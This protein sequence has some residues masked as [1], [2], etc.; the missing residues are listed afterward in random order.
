MRSTDADEMRALAAV[1]KNSDSD[2]VEGLR[3]SLT[4]FWSV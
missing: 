2:F 1:K 4:L 3:Y